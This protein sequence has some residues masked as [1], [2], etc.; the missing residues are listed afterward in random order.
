MV[1][2]LEKNFNKVK[3]VNRISFSVRDGECFGLL[4]VNGAG[5]TTAFRLLT[6]DIKGTGDAL[7]DSV[8]LNKNRRAVNILKCQ[9][10]NEVVQ[11][12][13]NT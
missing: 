1:H 2:Q 9:K 5:K 3:A 4:G 12:H 6:G 7:I 13:T 11:E 10:C 8:T